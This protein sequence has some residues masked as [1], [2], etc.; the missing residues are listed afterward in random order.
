MHPT[1]L[2]RRSVRYE[3]HSDGHLMRAM[4]LRG[5]GEITGDEV[6]RPSLKDGHVLVRITHSG[7][8]GTDLKIYQG[9]IPAR[10]PLI[11]GHEM[12]GEIVDGANAAGLQ[13]GDRV[14]VDPVLF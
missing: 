13:P 8:C 5:P 2:R 4:V 6:A 1:A 11:M 7:L 12:A 9:A 3:K 14:I 10:Y